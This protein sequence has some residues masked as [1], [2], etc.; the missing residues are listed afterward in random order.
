M[1]LESKG[2]GMAPPTEEQEGLQ[3]LAKLIKGK[4]REE[5]LLEVLWSLFF[6]LSSIIV[7]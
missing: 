7:Y 4:V 6:C 1:D 5:F 2:D 3:E